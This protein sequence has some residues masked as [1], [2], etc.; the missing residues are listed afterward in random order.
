MSTRPAKNP[1]VTEAKVVRDLET[2][3]AAAMEA[4]AFAPALRAIELLGRHIGMWKNE[5]GQ[6]PSLADLIAEAGAQAKASHD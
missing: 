4:E 3:R 1:L 6:Q 2:L 5:I